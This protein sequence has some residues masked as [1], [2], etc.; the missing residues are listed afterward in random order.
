M[1]LVFRA[2]NEYDILCD[3]INNGIASKKMLYDL[4]RIHLEA[5]EGKYLE[6]LSF[7]EREEYIKGNIKKY[8]KTHRSKLDKR[9]SYGNRDARN[10]INSFLKNEDN[11]SYFMI[12][13]YLS[14]LNNHLANGSRVQTEWISTTTNFDSVYKYYKNQDVHEIAI[15]TAYINGVLNPSTFVVDLSDKEKLS[16][17]ECLGKKIDVSTVRKLNELVRSNPEYDEIAVE[18]FHSRLFKPTDL[19]FMGFNFATA[20]HEICFY[21]HIDSR[22]VRAILERLHVDLIF[23]QRFN[24]QYINLS[25][26]EQKKALIELKGRMN[27]AIINM[28]DPYMMYVFEQLYLYNKSRDKIAADEKEREKIEYYRRSI[29]ANTVKYLPSVLIKK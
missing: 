8:I 7:K 27:N 23:L 19:K 12:L 1:E 24:E 15:C 9:F 25:K 16:Q 11:E 4:T 21:N 29:L 6:N 17:L 3:P 28:N 10:T 13:Q 22:C 2:L 14:T 18:Y 20:A 5:K 26:E